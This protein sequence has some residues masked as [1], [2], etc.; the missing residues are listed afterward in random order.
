M[1]NQGWGIVGVL[2]LG[3][4]GSTIVTAQTQ[5]PC[6]GGVREEVETLVWTQQ[7][8][9]CRPDSFFSPYCLCRFH[10][11]V[12]CNFKHV[13]IWVLSLSTSGSYQLSEFWLKQGTKDCLSLKTLWCYTHLHVNTRTSS[14]SCSCFPWDP[15]SPHTHT[16]TPES[17]APTLYSLYY[18]VF[19]AS[20]RF[21]LLSFSVSCFH[22]AP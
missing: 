16:H 21:I 6:S 2:Y 20:S 14:I 8:S 1:I 9:K 22:T 17:H 12:Q 15:P 10:K 18:P 4:C 3:H 19:S 11:L 7:T 5:H 13:N